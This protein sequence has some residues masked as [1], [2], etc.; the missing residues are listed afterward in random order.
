M[1]AGAWTVQVENYWSNELT[2]NL[3][4][5]KYRGAVLL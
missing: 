2:V 1:A 3:F 5:N 4:K